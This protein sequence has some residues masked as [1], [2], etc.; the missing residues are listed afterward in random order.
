L[1]AEALFQQADLPAQRGLRN[2]KTFSSAAEIQF[3]R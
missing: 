3:I 1:C 2:V